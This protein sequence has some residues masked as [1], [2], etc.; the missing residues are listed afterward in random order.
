MDTKNMMKQPQL[1]NVNV[2]LKIHLN[3]I[4]ARDYLSGRAA[5]SR[6]LLTSWAFFYSGGSPPIENSL[7]LSACGWH[8]EEFPRQSPQCWELGPSLPP[9]V[10]RIL[11]FFQNWLFSVPASKLLATLSQPCGPHCAKTW[12]A[13]SGL[14]FR[15]NTSPVLSSCCQHRGTVCNEQSSCQ[16]RPPQHETWSISKLNFGHF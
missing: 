3:R 9:P 7:C 4:K 5:C 6:S 16:S 10:Q 11:T 13:R 8:A 1:F 14:M 15:R 2:Y 12:D